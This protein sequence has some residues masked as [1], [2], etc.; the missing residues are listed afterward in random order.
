MCFCLLLVVVDIH[1][2]VFVVVDD[3]NDI[4]AAQVQRLSMEEKIAARQLALDQQQQQQ[5]QQQPSTASSPPTLPSATLPLA[6]PSLPP[7]S[8]SAAAAMATAAQV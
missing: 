7:V 2:R 5:Q 6:P 3:A 4:N 8:P 1:H